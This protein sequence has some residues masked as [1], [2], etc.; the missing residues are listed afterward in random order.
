MFEYDY[1]MKSYDKN[2]LAEHHS[3]LKDLLILNSSG[4]FK[5]SVMLEAMKVLGHMVSL[6]P[7][8]TAKTKIHCV[9]SSPI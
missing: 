8:Q 9:K 7:T 2:A 3:V 1:G 4:I 6:K 5:K